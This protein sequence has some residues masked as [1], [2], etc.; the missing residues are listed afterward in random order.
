MIEGKCPK[1]GYYRVGWALLNPRHQTC[2][3]CGTGLGISDGGRKI[4]TG[5]SPFSAERYSLNLPSGAKAGDDKKRR[6][7]P[8]G[9]KD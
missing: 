5:Y 4:I 2:T 6:R 1:C 3:K 9:G 8:D 7:E